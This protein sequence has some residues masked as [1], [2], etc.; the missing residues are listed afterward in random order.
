MV[1]QYIKL[2]PIIICGWLCQKVCYHHLQKKINWISFVCLGL[3]CF[4][5]DHISVW[6]Y[7]FGKIF[8][9]SL[10]G[11]STVISA[12]PKFNRY[13]LQNEGTL[14]KASYPKSFRD[15]VGSKGLIAIHG[16][17][18][19][20]LHG[21]AASQMTSE[22]LKRNFMTDIQIILQRTMGAWKD[23]QVLFEDECRKASV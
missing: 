7:R 18:H 17:L 5:I 16:D 13:I 6:E 19:R 3:N 14:F 22:K 8:T 15:L 11:K 12:D 1:F 20:K 2:T 21:I 9:C 4:V 23:R 10:F